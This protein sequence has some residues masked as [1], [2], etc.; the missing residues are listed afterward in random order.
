MSTAVSCNMDTLKLKLM[1]LFK[2]I[3]IVCT[4]SFVLNF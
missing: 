1:N 2:L 3:T 4:M